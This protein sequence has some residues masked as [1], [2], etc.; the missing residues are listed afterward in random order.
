MELPTECIIRLKPEINESD[1]AAPSMMPC[2]SSKDLVEDVLHSS[3]LPERL[4]EG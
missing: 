1:M 3:V 4:K 2:T